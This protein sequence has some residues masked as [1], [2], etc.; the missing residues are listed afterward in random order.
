[1]V[2][3]FEFQE[4]ISD[5]RALKNT[6]SKR[7]VVRAA[8]AVNVEHLGHDSHGNIECISSGNLVFVTIQSREQFSKA[9]EEIALKIRTDIKK[10]GVLVLP[11]NLKLVQ[12]KDRIE[13]WA[14]ERIIIRNSPVANSIEG[15]FLLKDG[16]ERRIN[17][18]KQLLAPFVLKA[19]SFPFGKRAP[20]KTFVLE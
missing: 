6:A 5:H 20:S 13:K 15:A 3:D 7:A 8:S 10:Y 16:F 18:Q 17:H 14:A 4:E 12:R 9:L 1:M 19:K 11:M 2:V